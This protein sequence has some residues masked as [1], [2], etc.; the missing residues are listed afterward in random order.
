MTED[1]RAAALTLLI[2][3]HTEPGS[4]G[5]VIPPEFASPHPKNAF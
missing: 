2:L 3:S 4:R 5:S 1:S